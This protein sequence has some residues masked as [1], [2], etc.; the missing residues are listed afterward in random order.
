MDSLRTKSDKSNVPAEAKEQEAKQ[1]F[2]NFQYYFNETI[3]HLRPG[4][5]ED[6]GMFSS[7]TTLCR[8]QIVAFV[9][10]DNM[11]LDINDYDDYNDDYDY[12]DPILCTT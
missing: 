9:D 3:E 6:P 8:R 11:D 2:E 12:D 10:A 1:I 7:R 5:E 4:K